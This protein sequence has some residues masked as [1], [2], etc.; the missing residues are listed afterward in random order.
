[1]ISLLFGLAYLTVYQ[2]IDGTWGLLFSLFG[3]VSLI[4]GAWLIWVPSYAKT[5]FHMLYDTKGKAMIIGIAILAVSVLFT[6]IA[7]AKV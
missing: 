1:V 2:A 4:K 5:K 6:W 7:V 3:Y